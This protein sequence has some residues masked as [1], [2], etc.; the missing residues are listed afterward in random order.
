M[1]IDSNA[2]GINLLKLNRNDSVIKF[3][4][5]IHLNRFVIGNGIIYFICKIVQIA[6]FFYVHTRQ[7][8]YAIRDHKSIQCISCCFVDVIRCANFNVGLEKKKH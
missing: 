2:V 5:N 3:L 6:T 8:N 4:T 1:T 7:D